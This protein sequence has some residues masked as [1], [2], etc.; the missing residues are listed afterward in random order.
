[1]RTSPSEDDDENDDGEISST[2]FEKAAAQKD[3][4]VGGG[5]KQIWE[6]VLAGGGI[7]ASSDLRVPT[8]WSDVRGRRSGVGRFWG[9]TSSSRRLA[10]VVCQ[11]RSFAGESKGFAS[12]EIGLSSS[13]RR[14]ASFLSALIRAPSVGVDYGESG[15]SGDEQ[16][17]YGSAREECRASRRRWWIWGFHRRRGLGDF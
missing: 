8:L 2:T 12:G 13:G 7:T 1:M 6:S 16:G 9:P 3:D 5:C 4:L 15:R 11:R 10:N 17:A 14:S